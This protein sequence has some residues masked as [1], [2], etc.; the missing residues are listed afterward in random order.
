MLM[1]GSDSVHN[2]ELSPSLQQ[3]RVLGRDQ[4]EAQAGLWA[5]GY[6]KG[7]WPRW[8]CR[9]GTIHGT[10]VEASSLEVSKKPVDVALEDRV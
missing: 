4:A 7:T 3:P 8:P 6:K 10:M 1:L 2:S 5:V 9:V